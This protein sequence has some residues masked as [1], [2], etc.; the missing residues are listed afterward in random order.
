MN[1]RQ[2]AKYYKK[3]YEECLNEPVKVATKSVIPEHYR[4]KREMDL[5]NLFDIGY[6]DDAKDLF[7]N[8]FT[9]ELT[10]LI[11]NN[12]ITV[13]HYKKGRQDVFE[14]ELYLS[15]DKEGLVEDDICQ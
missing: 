10:K 13:H 3:K 1:A 14:T 2:K 6:T 8:E 4:F 12:N 7:L 9:Y 15:F 11:K 5:A